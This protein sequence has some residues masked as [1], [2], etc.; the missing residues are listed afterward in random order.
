M[1]TI[2]IVSTYATSSI[3]EVAEAAP[4]ACLWFQ[5]YILTNR[6]HVEQLVRRAER[7]G[8]KALVVTADCPYAGK[9]LNDERQGFNPQV[10]CVLL[11]G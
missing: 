5:L 7:A 4:G 3:E 2:M 11:F 10:R 6:K 8:Y 1:G 9:K